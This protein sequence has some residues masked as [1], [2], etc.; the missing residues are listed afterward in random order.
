M[1][2][3]RE[4]RTRINLLDD[5]EESQ[6]N[7]TILAFIGVKQSE[8]ASDEIESSN[9]LSSSKSGRTTKRIAKSKVNR[10]RRHKRRLAILTK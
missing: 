8:S 6:D 5:Q 3:P 4:S 10:E 1:V 9:H 7:R 2:Y